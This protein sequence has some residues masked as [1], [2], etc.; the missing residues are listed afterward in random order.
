M[1]MDVADIFEGRILNKPEITIT[2]T[3]GRKGRCEYSYVFVEGLML[4]LIELKTDI[5]SIND[6]E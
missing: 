4:L 3:M 5:R 2:G 6:G 1:W